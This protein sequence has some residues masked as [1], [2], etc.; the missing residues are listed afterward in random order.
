MEERQAVI[1][2]SYREIESPGASEY[3]FLHHH[4]ALTNR[5]KLRGRSLADPKPQQNQSLIGA[6]GPAQ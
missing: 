2:L 4:K 1:S 3:S 5:G 6:S